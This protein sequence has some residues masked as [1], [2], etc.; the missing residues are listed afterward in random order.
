MYVHNDVRFAEI[1][2]RTRTASCDKNGIYLVRS[3][4]TAS[5]VCRGIYNYSNGKI[6]LISYMPVCL[7]ST[8]CEP[9]IQPSYIPAFCYSVLLVSFCQSHCPFFTTLS[10]D[11]LS[12]SN[13]FP[14]HVYRDTP[15]IYTLHT[16]ESFVY[17]APCP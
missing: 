3:G 10:Q 9:S 11:R 7:P 17:T 6:N 15:V 5:E 14:P 1:L 4:G 12:D 13:S 16:K 2:T 8:F